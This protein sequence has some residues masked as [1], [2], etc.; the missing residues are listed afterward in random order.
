M[1]IAALFTI[2][3]TWK[4]AKCSSTDEWIK[5]MWGVCVCIKHLY[6]VICWWTLCFHILAIVHNTSMNTGVHIPFELVF[7]LFWIYTQVELLDGMVVLFLVFWE[8]SVLF[9][10]VA[11]T[12]Y[13]ATNGALS[14]PFSLHP[15]Q[16]LLLVVFL[17]I[18][19]LSGMRWYLI[20]VLICISLMINDVEDL[21]M[22]LLAICMSSLEKM[23]IQLFWQFVKADSLFSYNH[24]KKKILFILF[25]I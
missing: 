12:I 15:H 8:T 23:S 6:P 10:T 21:F 17:M 20:V 5:K 9:S 22:C 13:V 24:L 2:A 16:H 18:A 14:V 1:F 25:C 19:I 3:K 4:E 11:A 7:W